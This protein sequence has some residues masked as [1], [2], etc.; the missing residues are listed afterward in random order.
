MCSGARALFGDGG[1]KRSAFA[2]DRSESPVLLDGTD[3]TLSAHLG[4]NH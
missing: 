4:L 1:L 3:D 2:G